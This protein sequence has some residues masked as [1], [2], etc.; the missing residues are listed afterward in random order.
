M[1]M[2]NSG[3]AR[4]QGLYMADI[5]SLEDDGYFL[6]YRSPHDE[7][8][9]NNPMANGHVAVSTPRPFFHLGDVDL[10]LTQDVQ[11][12]RDMDAGICMIYCLGGSWGD[13]INGRGYDISQQHCPT[14]LGFDDVV[15]METNQ[16]KGSHIKMMSFYIQK[17]FFDHSAS[18]D[19][20]L[21]ALTDWMKNEV[22]FR[23][24][25]GSPQL[26][27]V[28]QRLA[29]NPY[30]GFMAELYR[31][32]LSLEAL[33]CMADY[34]RQD[35]E[36][37]RANLHEPNALAH[38]ARKILNQSLV[39]MPKV[40]DLARQLGTNETKLRRSFKLTFGLSILDYVQQIRL[41]AAKVMVQEKRFSIAEIAYRVGYSNASNFSNAYKRYF[42]HAPKYEISG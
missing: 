39:D 11:F 31:E 32:S 38:E 30:E 5:L 10:T 22:T 19:P 20:A 2:V 26:S 14:I 4:E 18:A 27:F 12:E 21:M 13:K 1:G 6:N 9:E 36:S 25:L 37:V 33:L 3:E 8:G 17:D 41:E 29:N 16:T 40:A 28:M 15:E 7:V 34:A 35:H 24:L 42:G 23:K